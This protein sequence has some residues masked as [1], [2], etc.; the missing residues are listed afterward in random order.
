[1]VSEKK[2]GF[3]LIELMI[4]VAII[5]ILVAIAYP[6]YINYKIRVHRTD[7]QSEMMAIA[8]S[9][10]QFKITNGTYTNATISKIY[11]G[12]VTPVSGEALY[13]LDLETTASTWTLKAKPKNGTLMQGNGYII[14]TNDNLKCWT[15]GST[16]TPSATTNWDGK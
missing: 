14:L 7:A 13:D 5:A 4:V 12:T 9:L 8:H 16:C 10:N 6:S 3:T 15:K 11:G 1:M 2:N